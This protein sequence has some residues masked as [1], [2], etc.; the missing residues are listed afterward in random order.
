MFIKYNNAKKL[1]AF[2]RS[3]NPAIKSESDDFQIFPN[4]TKRYI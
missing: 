2:A 1:F 3:Y 4:K